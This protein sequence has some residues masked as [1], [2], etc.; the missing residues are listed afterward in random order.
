MLRPLRPRYSR[1]VRRLPAAG[2]IA[3]SAVTQPACAPLRQPGTPSSTEAVQSTRV[4]PNSARH[5]PAA[6]FMDARGS[7]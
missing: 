2:S 3:Y 1:G 4:S 5:D 6:F 7:A